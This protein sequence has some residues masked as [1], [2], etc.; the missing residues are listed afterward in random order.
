MSRSYRGRNNYCGHNDSAYTVR[1]KERRRKQNPHIDEEI[2]RNSTSCLVEEAMK[3]FD[4]FV[5]GEGDD[6]T[7]YFQLPDE[8]GWFSIISGAPI[9]AN[10]NDMKLFKSLKKTYIFGDTIRSIYVMPKYRGMGYQSEIIKTVKKCVNRCGSFAM[11]FC[12][13]FELPNED[14]I[15]TLLEAMELFHG[16][17]QQPL[18]YET[19]L[20]KQIARF[21]REHFRNIDWSYHAGH[22]D[23][24]QQYI[25]VSPHIP[26][27]DWKVIE[28]L[29]VA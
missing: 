21:E 10:T 1:L 13:P 26:Q 11:A 15:T 22:T 14:K 28:S 4:T 25:Y 8:I 7:Y 18:D 16:E 19:Q 24:R 2:N 29:L 9:Y 6:L 27:D 12:D 17:H 5:L 3:K 23:I 20:E